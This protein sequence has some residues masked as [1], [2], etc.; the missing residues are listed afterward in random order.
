MDYSVEIINELEKVF[1][2][3]TLH[4]PMQV[5]RY[6]TGSELIYVVTGVASAN[7]ARVNLVIERFVGGGFAGQVYRVK[8]LEIDSQSG[9][10]EGLEAGKVYAMKILLPPT[11]FSLLFRNALY[12]IGFQGPFQLQ[13]NPFAARAGAL[14]QKLIRMGAKIRFGDEKT[15]VDIYATFVDHVLGSCGELSEWVEGRTW[16]LEVDE[17]MDLLKRWIR[18]KDIDP[19]DL[20]SPEYRS[21]RE[22]MRQFVELLHDM[23]GHEFAR[24]YEWSTCKSQPN[25]LKRISSEESPFE[26]LVA[27]DFRAGLS[28]LP[29]LPMS[30]GDFKLIAKG[31]MRGSLVQFDRGDIG[32]LDRFVEAN[33]DKFGDM[34]EMLEELK[35]TEGIYRESVPD[36]THNHFRL[37]YKKRLWSTIF[38][39]YLTGWEI[40]NLIDVSSKEKLQGSRSLTFLF[41]VIGLLPLLGPFLRKIWCRPDWRRHYLGMLTSWSYLCRAVRGKAAEKIIAWHRSGRIEDKRALILTKKTWRFL[42]HLPLSVFPAGLHRLTT[43]WNYAKEKLYY[44]TVRPLRLYFNAELREQWLTD[45]VN[46]GKKNHLL[47]HEDAEVIIS[48]IKEPFIQ[49]YL[50]SLAVHVCTLPVTQVIS[51]IV[52]MIFWIMNP[53]MSREAR[54]LAMA[55]ILIAFQITPVSPGS[56]VRGLY[57]LYL[58]I[59]ERNFKDY[60]IAVFLGFFKYIGYLAFPIQMGY[61]YPEL[62]RFMAAY[63]A[64]EAVHVVPVFGERGALLERSVFCLFYNWPLTIRR[65]MIKRGEIRAKTQPRYWHIVL[66]ALVGL[67]I[68]G[69]TDYYFLR[70]IG[71]TPVL[72]DIWVLVGLVPLLSGSAVTLGALG[73]TLSMRIILAAACGGFTGVL[74]MALTGVIVQ[75]SA[76]GPGEIAINGLWQL[77]IFT[78]FSTIGAILTELMLPEPEEK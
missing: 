62:A 36:I 49:K 50:K 44:L 71:E 58:V 32:K 11:D 55:G 41:F 61:R 57:V 59:R 28:L 37:F 17:R 14:W 45:M 30:P 40:R 15:V 33:Q 51:L 78:I 27:V 34:I 7:E 20:G 9:P 8:I 52:A 22:F 12:R 39:S 5:K 43:D 76:I 24:Q 10:I 56:L 35:T 65:R 67:G 18:D 74:H 31:L 72:K 23:G 69:F 77:F 38:Q 53:E 1:R 68:F 54:G 13:V 26:G 42:Y 25:C 70:D 66:C 19:M 2:S 48:R 46:E 63:W 75:G 6:E 64:T 21:K 60:N 4:R 29:F 16:R 3:A 47:T 73:A